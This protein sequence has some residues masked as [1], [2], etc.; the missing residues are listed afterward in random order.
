MKVKWFMLNVK[1]P[2]EKQFLKSLIEAYNKPLSG[3]DVDNDDWNDIKW[4]NLAHSNFIQ[5]LLSMNDET[6][7]ELKKKPFFA[8]S[9]V[10]A[11]LTTLRV[12]FA[13]TRITVNN[14]N[15]QDAIKEFKNFDMLLAMNKKV[16]LNQ[17]VTF[18]FQYNN[19]T[20]YGDNE[21]YNNWI[22]TR[23]ILTHSITSEF[24]KIDFKKLEHGIKLI[25][26]TFA[27]HRNK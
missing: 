17:Q 25:E 16:H 13:N 12:V 3:W 22:D 18:Y 4:A 15:H 21:T 1:T 2:K 26:A 14:R 8:R 11:G 24:D 10:E 5:Q 20:Q 7:S 27:S 23:N 19:H 9:Y 6:F